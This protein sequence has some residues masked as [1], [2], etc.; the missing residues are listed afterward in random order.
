M[1]FAQNVETPQ[2][3]GGLVVISATCQY[4]EKASKSTLIVNYETSKIHN[5]LLIHVHAD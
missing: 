2:K 1:I 3:I 4:G 5:L